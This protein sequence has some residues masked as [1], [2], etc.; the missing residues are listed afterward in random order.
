MYGIRSYD[1]RGHF[2]N[3]HELMLFPRDVLVNKAF[4]PLAIDDDIM[5]IVVSNPDD[6]EIIE[7]IGDYVPYN[8]DKLVGIRRDI[9]DAIEEYYDEDVATSDIEDEEPE[10]D[11]ELADD[12]SDIVDIY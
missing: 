6:D 10:D 9:L 7:M 5:T 8:V 4:I 12:E 3:H 2:F 11:E 1:A